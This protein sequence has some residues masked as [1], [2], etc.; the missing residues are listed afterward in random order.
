MEAYVRSS[1]TLSCSGSHLSQ[2]FRALYMHSGCRSGRSWPQP[3]VCR[4]FV[5]SC[6]PVSASVQHE[7]KLCIADRDVLCAAKANAIKSTEPDGG[8]LHAPQ[9]SFS[10]CARAAGFAAV[11]MAALLHS[12]DAHAAELVP[13]DLF[14]SF[15][16]S[17]RTLIKVQLV[18]IS[19]EG[20]HRVAFVMWLLCTG[21]SCKSLNRC[22]N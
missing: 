15:L 10:S 9:L 18:C 19:F 22:L 5:D 11:S 12:S 13:L 20:A 16:V 3:F 21:S 14:S 2:D 1:G 17:F 7:G 8:C 6:R 4:A